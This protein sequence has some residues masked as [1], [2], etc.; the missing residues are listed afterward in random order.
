MFVSAR[1]PG[2]SCQRFSVPP[3]QE[4]GLP[5]QILCQQHKNMLTVTELREQD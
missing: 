3:L 4:P 1:L 5:L 2:D